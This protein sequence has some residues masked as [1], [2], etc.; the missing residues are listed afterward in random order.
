MEKYQ[1]I[2]VCNN[3]ERPKLQ[4]RMKLIKKVI[5]NELLVEVL[6]MKE[7]RWSKV[8]LREEL[9]TIVNGNASRWGV[10][11]RNAM[12]GVGDGRTIDL[13]WSGTGG[14]RLIEKYLGEGV[15]RKEHDIQGDWVKVDK[16]TLC[17]IYKE[18]KEGFE[19]EKY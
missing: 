14:V 16:S 2:Q 17:S 13:M 4:N 3:F 11:F 12:R 19:R 10:E 1:K 5:N 18:I 7:G 6:K 15:E 8:C 9:R